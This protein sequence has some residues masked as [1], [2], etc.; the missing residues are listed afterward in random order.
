MNYSLKAIASFEKD[1]KRLSKKYKSFKSDLLKLRTQLLE[2]PKS[3]ISLGNSCYKLRF[4]ISSKNKG[5]SAGARIITHLI[6]IND[7]AGI[8]YLLAIY[9]KSEQENI[10]D[11]Q[12]LELLKEIK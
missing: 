4:S 1:I 10:T 8:I 11:K 7:D 3:G 2:N 6:I 12:I 5:K 9:D